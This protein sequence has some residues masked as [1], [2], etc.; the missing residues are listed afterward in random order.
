MNGA[1]VHN[2]GDSGG[3]KRSATLLTMIDMKRIVSIGTIL[4]TLL[5]VMPLFAA[6]QSSN[7]KV[8][9]LKEENGKP[10]R[11]ASVILHPVGKDGRQSHGGKQLKTNGDGVASL[12]G[13]PYGKMRVQVIAPGMQTYGEDFD[14]NQDQQEI[15]V[16][17]KPPQ[18]QY[19]IY[20]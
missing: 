4:L 17:L 3:L 12:D 1:M 19:S 6:E 9:V 5:A 8:T 2:S 11:N 16:K 7:I 18:Q 20:K 10:V 14:I 13:I 15:V